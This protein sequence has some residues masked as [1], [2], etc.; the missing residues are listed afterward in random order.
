[1]VDAGLCRLRAW[2]FQARNCA[3]R[4]GAVRRAF[5]KSRQL[6]RFHCSIKTDRFFGTHRTKIK[7]RKIAGA[8]RLSVGRWLKRVGDPV[9]IGEPVVEIDTYYMTHEILGIVFLRI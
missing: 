3:L 2:S 4:R 7:V 9:S 5:Q 8:L 1:M 6:R